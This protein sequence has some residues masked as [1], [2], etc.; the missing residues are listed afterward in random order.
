MCG[1]E[2]SVKADAEGFE[3]KNEHK[4]KYWGKYRTENKRARVSVGEYMCS[5]FF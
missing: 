4:T 1:S 2:F 3:T 5:F